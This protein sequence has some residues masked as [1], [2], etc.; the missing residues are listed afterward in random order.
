[1]SL[2]NHLDTGVK[3][4]KKIQHYVDIM[5][6]NVNL[7]PRYFQVF[8]LHLLMHTAKFFI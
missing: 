3:L 4:I 6:T 7:M 2:I 8:F 5:L 1:M